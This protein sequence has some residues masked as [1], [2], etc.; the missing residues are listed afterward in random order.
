MLKIMKHLRNH[1]EEDV[2]FMKSS[3]KYWAEKPKR[4]LLK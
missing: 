3:N 2:T 4:K 1:T